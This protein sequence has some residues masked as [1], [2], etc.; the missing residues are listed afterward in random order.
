MS[1]HKIRFNINNFFR[2]VKLKKKYLT[3]LRNK[4]CILKDTQGVHYKVANSTLF[5]AKN[6]INILQEDYRVTYVLQ[7][8]FT[9]TN[10][11]FQV[12]QYD[13]TLIF[14]TSAGALGYTGKRKRS[15]SIIFKSFYK[16]L[17]TKLT[18]LKGKTL[19]VHFKN[20]G[21]NKVWMLKKLRKKLFV[22]IVR[23]YNLYPHNGCRKPKVRRKKIRTK[24]TT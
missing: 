2:D 24:R 3:V 4:L 15:R 17:M 7:I 10:T 23:N 14:F 11:F 16:I 9:K 6:K 22:K 18:F 5:S 21:F 12:F 8:S 13:G 1:D 19:A 20:V